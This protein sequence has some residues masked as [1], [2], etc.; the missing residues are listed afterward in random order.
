MSDPAALA[1]PLA[2]FTTAVNF[3]LG[4]GVLGIPYAVASAGVLASSITLVLI[5]ALSMLTCSWLIEVGDRANALQNELAANTPF[6]AAA[7]AVV[8]EN[9]ARSLLPPPEDFVLQRE[10]LLGDRLVRRLDE[11][12]AAYRS[13]RQGSPQGARDSQLRKLMPSIKYEAWRHRELLPLQLLPPSMMRHDASQASE[14]GSRGHLCTT[15]P[16]APLGSAA[17][18]TNNSSK[19]LDGLASQEYSRTRS[20]SRAA[21]IF[22]RQ[23]SFSADL[24]AA[25]L[26]LPIRSADDEEEGSEKD[27]EGGWIDDERTMDTSLKYV[28]PSMTPPPAALPPPPTTTQSPPSCLVST[29]SPQNSK[30]E[31]VR[32]VGFSA[33]EGSCSDAPSDSYVKPLPLSPLPPHL[34]LPP[35]DWSTPVEISALEVAQLCT[36]FLGWRARAAWIASILALHVAAMWACCAIWITTAHA[37]LAGSTWHISPPLLLL[38]CAAVLLP[39]SM[40][41]GTE[42][43]QPP[44]A[45]ATLSTLALMGALLIWALVEREIGHTEHLFGQHDAPPPELMSPPAG[46]TDEWYRSLIFDGRRFGSSF[47]TFLFAYIV[48]QSVPTL[49][50]RAAKPAATRQALSAALVTCCMLY[51]ALGCAAALY[52]GKGTAK[53]VT[54]NFADLRGAPAGQPPAVW[55]RALSRWVLLLPCITTTAAFPLFNRV[56]AANFEPL[57]PSALRSQRTAAALCATSPFLLTACVHDTALVFSLCGLA[58]FAIVWFVPA[59]L[60]Y[61]ARRASIQRWGE[62]GRATPHS[63]CLSG[64]AAVAAVSLVG[65]V[66]F[67][68]NFWVVLLRPALQFMGGE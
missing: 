46:A 37:A 11:Y 18:S 22:L 27:T 19:S 7:R 14:T 24:A 50:R 62:A 51:L 23:A 59:A 33:H 26:S 28:P 52:F 3:V 6:A 41:G 64:P 15:D 42:A 44:L 32:R 39:L 35:P 58:G 45:V 61:A 68:F 10:S 13:W 47:A 54:L 21:P 8:H 20:G 56:L 38:P 5:G 57:L 16:A 48:Q 63:T 67:A 49:Q 4:A 66:A 60:Q 12:R 55:A 9:G 53:L 29:S 1:S 34:L 65:G 43:I 25:L 2:V 36:L 17:S 30:P 31:G 40:L